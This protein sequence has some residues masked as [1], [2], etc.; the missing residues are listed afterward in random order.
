[1]SHST[2][3]IAPTVTH[4][5]AS[6]DADPKQ[7]ENAN[8]APSHEVPTRGVLLAGKPVTTTVI[9]AATPNTLT[10]DHALAAKLRNHQAFVDLIET[11]LEDTT[12]EWFYDK[13]PDDQLS[14]KVMSSTCL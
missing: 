8:T 10:G 2:R 11:I 4:D 12:I 3:D 5:T 1:M 13:A 6:S 14:L 7:R 9:D